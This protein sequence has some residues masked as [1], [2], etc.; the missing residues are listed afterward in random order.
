MH[1]HAHTHTHARTHARTHAHT[2]T[3][4]THTHTHTYDRERLEE[5]VYSTDVDSVT[6]FNFIIVDEKHLE[7]K[8]R[9]IRRVFWLWGCP[10]C[11]IMCNKNENERYE[12]LSVVLSLRD[13]EQSV[14]LR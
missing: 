4:T 8:C 14:H 5:V 1:T 9:G 11:I 2:H 12:S 6:L 3:H 7:L 10:L 13:G